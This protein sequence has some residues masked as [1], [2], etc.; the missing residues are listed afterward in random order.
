[1][2]F[3]LLSF[4]IGWV[5]SCQPQDKKGL[6]TVGPPVLP[7][8]KLNAAFLI[9]DG[10]YNS[11][12]IAP[13]DIFQH[14]IFHTDKGIAVFTIAPKK[15]T[16][17][18]FEGLNILPDYSFED[19][20]PDIDILIV[21]SA[22]HSMD[23]DLENE[24]LIQ[25]VQTTGKKASYIFSLCD[26]AFILAKAKLLDTYE[27]TT[28]PS[29]IDRFKKAFPQL[30]VHKDVS[31]VH[32]RRAITSAGGAKSYD[33][34]LYLTELLYGKKVADGIAKGLVI[35]WDLSQVRHKTTNH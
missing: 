6:D 19:T 12:L 30:T 7:T 5:V 32:D 15:D 28:F 11:E 16:I 22:Q 17:T 31:F 18:T 3:F 4:V 24:A 23:S 1:M 20:Y 35:D 14:T 8:K 33:A 25:F 10:V 34:A 9:V 26:G 21:P 29:D 13:M 2:R 27:C